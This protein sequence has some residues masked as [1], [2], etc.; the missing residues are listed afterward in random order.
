VGLVVGAVVALGVVAAGPTAPAHAQAAAT[1][2]LA[3][4][5]PWIAPGAGF[6]MRFDATNVPAGSEVALTVHD[7]LQSRTAFTSS[8]DGTNLPP[9]RVRTTFPFGSLPVDPATGERVLTYPSDSLPTGVF[10]VEVDLRSAEASIAHFVTHIVIE[11][12]GADGALTGGQPLQVAW[13]WPLATEPGYTAGIPYNPDAYADLEPGGRLARQAAQ[14]D[15]DA[16][17]PLTLVPSPETL[18][19]WNTFAQKAPELA[20]GPAAIRSSIDRD[21]VLAGPFVP[22]DLPSLFKADLAGVV[23]P[24]LRRGVS[25][26]EQFF[27]T[28]FEPNPT[29]AYPG[30][31]DAQSLQ[32][33]QNAST[34]QIVVE[35][36]ALTPVDEKYTPAHPYTMQVVPGDES[37]DIT[38][39]AT[40]RALEQFLTGNDPPALRAAHLLAGLAV[41]AGEQ[42]SILRGVAIA[43]PD[44]WDANDTFVTQVLAGLRGNPLLQPTTVQGLLQS[45]PPATVD[46]TIGGTPVYRQLQPLGSS[47]AAPVTLEQ[48]QAGSTAASQVASV[49]GDTDPRAQ[50]AQRALATSVSSLWETRQGRRDARALL[51]SLDA[52]LTDYVNQI[53][54][55]QQGTVT[56]TSS[57]ADIPISFE[58]NGDSDVTVHMVLQSDRLLFPDGPARDVVLP[59]HRNT[60]VRVAVETRGSGTAPVTMTVTTANGLVIPSA[61]DAKIKV[62]STFVSGVGVIL[63]VAAIVFLAV[64]WGVDIHRRRKKRAR[65][66]HPTFHVADAPGSPA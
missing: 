5:S 37:S 33:L 10:P 29:T 6:V 39:L 43:N 22:L 24:E 26:L 65:G 35:G 42:P 44:R 48:Y 52:P 2:T 4:Q 28:P 32:L 9:T 1:F 17:V 36:D 16:D 40:D 25:T 23:N 54:V 64:W 30:P 7:A 11:P 15:A 34:R 50:R 27:G 38:V 45:V 47:P 46:G 59:A 41:V 60:T 55:Q 14:I 12:V 3:S 56:I 21:Q 53:E 20:A 18:D 57:R 31:L 13:V 63:T 58:N 66:H 62:R 51:R 61:Q 19:T 49:F 8:I